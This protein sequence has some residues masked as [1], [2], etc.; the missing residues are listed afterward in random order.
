MG[1]KYQL[2]GAIC[3]IAVAVCVNVA[4][5]NID[6][7]LIVEDQMIDHTNEDKELRVD[8]F[9]AEYRHFYCNDYD[10][11]CKICSRYT[12]KETLDANRYTGVDP[13]F[14]K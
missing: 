10:A 7:E 11:E 12:G 1:V 14:R 9:P 3:L 13:P 6:P 5:N 8:D 4:C 2:F